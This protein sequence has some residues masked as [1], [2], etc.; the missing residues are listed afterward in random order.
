M[1]SKEAWDELP[2]AYQEIIK[3]TC[4]DILSWTL[5]GYDEANPAALQRLTRE[6]G[7]MLHE[8]S[9]EIMEAAWRESNAYLE[10]QAAADPLFRTVF[11]SFSAFRNQAFPYSAGNEGAYARFTFPKIE[12]G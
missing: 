2:T 8:F 1:I 7:V 6:E 5:A 12:A 11:E 9:S 4:G 3:T 10:E